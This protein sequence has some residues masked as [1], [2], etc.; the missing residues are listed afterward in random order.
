MSI[1][2]DLFNEQMQER[3]RRLKRW[4]RVIY[5]LSAC[6]AA[7]YLGGRPGVI[8]SERA[9]P[10]YI[11]AFLALWLMQFGIGITKGVLR[12]VFDVLWLHPVALVMWTALLA[13]QGVWVAVLLH[14][15]GGSVPVW[16]GIPVIQLTAGLF[17]LHCR[18]SL[19]RDDHKDATT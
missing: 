10:Y 17:A 19:E 7:V 3:R 18:A 1:W 8:P 13:A 2:N 12:R 4:P 16:L 11:S 5:L 15:S 6:V 9:W 14:D